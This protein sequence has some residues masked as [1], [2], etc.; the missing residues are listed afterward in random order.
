MIFV[1]GQHL[2]DVAFG[3]GN[4]EGLLIEFQLGE[5][6]LLE[7]LMPAPARFLALAMDQIGAFDLL[8]EKVICSLAES[9]AGCAAVACPASRCYSRWSSP[10][11]LGAK[12][13]SS[14]DGPGPGAGG[15][16]KMKVCHSSLSRA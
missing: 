6:G 4:P 5:P 3:I 10:P 8:D 11:A 15:S 2:G 13:V 1:G 14:V 9:R 7:L 12:A 16:L